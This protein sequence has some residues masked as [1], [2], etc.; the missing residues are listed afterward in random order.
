MTHYPALSISVFSDASKRPSKMVSQFIL[1]L[2]LMSA[3]PLFAAPDVRYEIG[4]IQPIS[5]P[6]GKVVSLTIVDPDAPPVG[7]GN[8]LGLAALDNLI[9]DG[10]SNTVRASIQVDSIDLQPCAT[11]PVQKLPLFLLSLP[12]TYSV[13]IYDQ[14]PDFNAERLVETYQIEVV[15]LMAGAYH[16]TPAQGSIQSGVGVIRGWACDAVSVEISI[17]GGERIP[18]AYGTSRGDTMSVCNDADNGYGMV[19]AWGNL[20]EGMHRL[21]TFVN[22]NKVADWNGNKISDV[23]FEVAGIGEPF[24]KGLSATYEL[25][26]FP[27][28]GETVTVEWSE[29][30]QNFIIVDHN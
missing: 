5:V 16:E 12:G 30:D 23:E 2:C 9:I 13:E 4:S 6:S 8:C 20:G 11:T 26:D 17:D 19:I 28:P 21:Q 29:P 15:Q 22:A 1:W 24:A 14:S 25:Q 3:F 10:L 27:A 7:V 18:V